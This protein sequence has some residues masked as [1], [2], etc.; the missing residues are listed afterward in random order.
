VLRIVMYPH[1]ALRYTSR[2]VTQI[3]DDL[4]AT[5][6]E[7]FS[8][9]YA[10]RGVGLAA[11]QVGLPF[12]F[13]ILNLTADPE[14]KDQELVFINPEIVKRH[15]SAEDEEG[16]LSLPGLYSKV[17]RAKKIKVRA[18][19]LEGELVDHEGE[20]LFS[21]AAQHENDHI[22]GKL[23]ID[24]LGPLARHSAKDKLR[25]FETQFRLAQESGE[26]PADSEIIKQLDAMTGPYH[27]HPASAAEVAGAD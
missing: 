13:F 6:Q 3:D 12:R 27:A 25:E 11:N 8:L 1:P 4:R 23:F 5:V 2:P 20:E 22:D 24:Y 18:Y 15:S 17:R 7:M 9:M 10:A 16:C 14:Q 26:Y 19:N 21:R